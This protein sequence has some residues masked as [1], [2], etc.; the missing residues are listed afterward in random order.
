MLRRLV[1]ATGLAHHRAYVQFTELVSDL[2]PVPAFDVG[3]EPTSQATVGAGEPFAAMTLED[4][5]ILWCW[6]LLSAQLEPDALFFW[7]FTV[8]VLHRAALHLS[9]ETT[10]RCW[11]A[12]PLAV[13]FDGC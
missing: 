12:A 13:V 7:Q 5:I 3:A 6:R 11:D 10:F 8:R 2:F 4:V 1:Q 9:P